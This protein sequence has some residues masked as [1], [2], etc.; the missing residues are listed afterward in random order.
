MCEEPECRWCPA[1]DTCLST[2]ALAYKEKVAEGGI[3]AIYDAYDSMI[4]DGKVSVGPA[5]GPP[6]TKCE[7]YKETE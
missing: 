4:R 6:R 7:H 1:L 3:N 2:W 5:T